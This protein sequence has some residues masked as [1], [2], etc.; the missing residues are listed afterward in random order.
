VA[1]VAKQLLTQAG[2]NVDL[3][4]MDL[5]TLVSRRSRPNGWNVFLSNSS[6]VS[7]LNPGSSNLMSGACNK[8]WF[9]WPCDSELEKLRDAFALASDERERKTIA[10]QIQVRAMGVGTH[11]PL[12]E[13]RVMVATRKNITGFITGFSTVYWNVE[14]Q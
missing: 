4:S 1:L 2:F 12:G 3:Q 7:R 9:G 14:K 11:V 5:E 10:E 6:S 13:Y 8:A